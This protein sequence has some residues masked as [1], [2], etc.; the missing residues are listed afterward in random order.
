VH[1]G[2]FNEILHSQERSIGVCTSNAMAKFQDFINYSALL[3]LP[4][5]G[6]DFTWSIGMFNV[7]PFSCVGILGGGFSRHV[8]KKAAKANVGSLPYLS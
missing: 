4:L 3:D 7:R 1:R 5:K 6:V 2:D 8:S